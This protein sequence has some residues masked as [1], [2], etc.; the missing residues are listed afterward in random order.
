VKSIIKDNFKVQGVVKPGAGADILTSSMTNEIRSLSKSEVV[1]F[2]GV[3]ND[4][5]RNNSSKALHQIMNFIINCEHTNIILITAPLRYDLMQSLYVNNEINSFNR[6]LKKITVHHHASI[7]DIV[8]VRNLL[9]NHGLHLNGQGKERLSNQIVSHIY[10]ILEQKTDSPITL[11]WKEVQKLEGTYPVSTAL[12]QMK[13]QEHMCGNGEPETNTTLSTTSGREYS[14]APEIPQ[15]IKKQNKE[16]M[17]KAQDRNII[18]DGSEKEEDPKTGLSEIA[19]VE[20]LT[21]GTAQ[22]RQTYDEPACKQQD[23]IG[24]NQ[25]GVVTQGEITDSRTSG[26]KRKTLVTRGNDFLWTADLRLRV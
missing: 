3:A 7:L 26:R 10:S 16:T 13:D 23:P 12:D 11:K 1:V 21:N 2:C 15:T 9:T 17:C 25:T 18:S 14:D 20:A 5:G 4:I 24:S 22:V 8:T 6:K 19:D